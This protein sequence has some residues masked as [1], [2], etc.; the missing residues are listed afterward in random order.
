MSPL[1]GSLSIA[2]LY[3]EVMGLNHQDTFAIRSSISIKIVLVACSSLLLY[4]TFVG[5][6]VTVSF[7]PAIWC[8]DHH[9]LTGK[10]KISDGSH[11]Y[12]SVA[13]NSRT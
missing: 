6:H 13:V 3:V 8:S 7:G 2:P 12:S 5:S 1:A 9:G 4:F 10:E 11:T